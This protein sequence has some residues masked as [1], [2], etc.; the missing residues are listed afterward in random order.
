MEGNFNLEIENEPVH[1]MW[2][3]M[4]YPIFRQTHIIYVSFIAKKHH[5]QNQC[6]FWEL[7]NLQRPFSCPAWLAVMQSARAVT[8]TKGWKCNAH[9]SR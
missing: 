7:V 9:T 4:G 1:T 5:P 6:F 8:P 3:G 2:N